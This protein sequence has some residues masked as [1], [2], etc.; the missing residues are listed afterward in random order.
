MHNANT[1]L[2]HVRRGHKYI[3][4]FSMLPD[5]SRSIYV[6]NKKNIDQAWPLYGEAAG[7]LDMWFA[8]IAERGLYASSQRQDMIKPDSDRY[9]YALAQ[10]LTNCPFLSFWAYA[11]RLHIYVSFHQVAQALGLNPTVALRENLGGKGLRFTRNSFGHYRVGLGKVIHTLGP[12]IADRLLLY[13]Q[14]VAH[15]LGVHP[16]SATKI[17][18]RLDLDLKGR[19]GNMAVEWGNLRRVRRTSPRGFKVIPES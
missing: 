3:V 16:V 5:G 2:F 12:D 17:I 10:A 13:R 7:Y 14:H 18:K 6:L 8:Q 1:F 4:V 19:D 11:T 9:P 15:F